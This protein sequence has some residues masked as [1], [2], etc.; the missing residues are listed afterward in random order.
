M[1]VSLL[2]WTDTGRRAGPKTSTCG[3]VGESTLNVY[4]SPTDTLSGDSP[5]PAPITRAGADTWHTNGLP[6][7]DNYYKINLQITTIDMTK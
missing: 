2:T 6:V 5:E 3:E 1:K 4:A 7:T